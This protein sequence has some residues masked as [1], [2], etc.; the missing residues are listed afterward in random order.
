MITKTEQN[1]ELHFNDEGLVNDTNKNIITIG[2]PQEVIDD[3]TNI[4]IGKTNLFKS[5][6]LFMT[7]LINRGDKLRGEKDFNNKYYQ[8]HVNS[9]RKIFGSDDFE[10]LKK[11]LIEN[12]IIQLVKNASAE[13][14]VCNTFKVSK[15]WKFKGYN[16]VLYH[17][18]TNE[19]FARNFQKMNYWVLPMN[20]QK[21][22][23]LEKKYNST[24]QELNNDNMNM[25]QIMNK[26]KE[27]EDRI[28]IL[29]K[30]NEEL[31]ASGT[32]KEI[33]YQ[34]YNDVD[35]NKMLEDAINSEPKK[36]DTPCQINVDAVWSDEPTEDTPM[37]SDDEEKIEPNP[38]VQLVPQQKSEYE[39]LVESVLRYFKIQ[40]GYWR[41]IKNYLLNT[42]NIEFSIMCD[43][44]PISG[45]NTRRFIEKLKK[46]A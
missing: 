39:L 12:N 41:K 9:H 16:T 24:Q 32:N 4:S 44:L 22:L 45:A 23:E 43:L 40:E 11:L 2:I 6:L 1:N 3:I 36:F 35:M 15:P 17:F 37:W 26:M 7:W 31:K 21:K 46:V 13:D 34:N 33:T 20:E 14:N 5:K 8:L 27:L 25:I 38:I 29:Q 28:E 30:E 19:A 18:S 42:D 10:K